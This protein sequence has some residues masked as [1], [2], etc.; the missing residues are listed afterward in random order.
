MTALNEY[1]RWN[2][3]M[4]ANG[5]WNEGNVVIGV[6][7]LYS[8]GYA[9]V[10][11][12]VS[13]YTVTVTC[14]TNIHGTAE[15]TDKAIV[16]VHNTANDLFGYSDSAV[17]SDGTVDVSINID[18]GHSVNVWLFFVKGEAYSSNTDCKN[19]SAV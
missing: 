19:V 5:V 14:Y 13:T 4:I 16:V 17:R 10:T 15:D 9:S 11:A 6:G 2:Q 7:S 1:V 12:Y 8:P 18:H 3:S